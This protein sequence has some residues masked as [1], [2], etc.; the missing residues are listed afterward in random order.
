MSDVELQVNIELFQTKVAYIKLMYDPVSKLWPVTDDVS[1]ELRMMTEQ[2]AA[3]I[4]KL[5]ALKQEKTKRAQQQ[6][7]LR[8]DSSQ[9]H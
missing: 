9:S 7:S 8:S 6:A 5:E 3:A 1:K 2:M 4:E